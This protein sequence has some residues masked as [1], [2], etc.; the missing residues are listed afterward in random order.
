LYDAA[1]EYEKVIQGMRFS[2]RHA[3]VSQSNRSGIFTFF[4]NQVRRKLHIVLCMSPVGDVFRLEF[5]FLKY[6]A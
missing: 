1:E 4:L 3:G 2:A 6:K 5:A